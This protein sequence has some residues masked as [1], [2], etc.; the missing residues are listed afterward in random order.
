MKFSMFALEKILYILHGQVF[1]MSE[2]VAMVFILFSQRLVQCLVF[3]MR[4]AN[5]G[6]ASMRKL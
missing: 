4:D 1:V 2:M 5:F 3:L 6:L